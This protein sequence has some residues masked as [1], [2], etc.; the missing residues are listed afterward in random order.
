MVTGISKKQPNSALLLVQA[1][2]LYLRVF[3]SLQGRTLEKLSLGWVPGTGEQMHL[4]VKV[5]ASVST[6]AICMWDRTWAHGCL[7]MR[8]SASMVLLHANL[9]N[10]LVLLRALII[11]SLCAW[12]VFLFDLQDL[13]AKGS[14]QIGGN[15][16]TNAGKACMRMEGH[17]QCDTM[18]C[19]VSP[20]VNESL[21]DCATFGRP[22]VLVDE[23][24]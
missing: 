23:P 2:T 11:C 20:C 17:Y 5:H 24:L 1:G 18:N 14:C 3:V 21:L 22:V 16:S 8:W 19:V 13:G 15:V 12:C 6:V 4:Q 7:I 9:S 10:S